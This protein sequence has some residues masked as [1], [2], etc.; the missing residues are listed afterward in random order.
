MGKDSPVSQR[1]NRLPGHKMFMSPS[2]QELVNEEP[3]GIIQSKQ[4]LLLHF[5]RMGV[6]EGN[7][8]PR[9]HYKA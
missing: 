7:D 5:Q 3:I 2:N 9:D 4:K 6:G 8:D 1:M